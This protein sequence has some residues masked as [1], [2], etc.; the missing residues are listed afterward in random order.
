VVSEVDHHAQA[1]KKQEDRP[2]DGEPRVFL[3]SRAALKTNREETS[4]AVDEGGDEGTQH[5]LG[6]TITKEVAQQPRRE[7]GRGE[8]ERDHSQTEDE[9][10]DRHNCAADRDEQCTGIVGGALEGQAIQV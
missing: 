1:D 10:D 7:L 8:L 5:H 6:P 4:C 2:A 9:S 3:C